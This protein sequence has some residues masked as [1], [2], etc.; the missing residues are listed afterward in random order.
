V[1]AEA[2]RKCRMVLLCRILVVTWQGHAGALQ[3]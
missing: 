2:C 3:V 1:S